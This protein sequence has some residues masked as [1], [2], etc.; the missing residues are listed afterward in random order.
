MIR[1]ISAGIDVGSSSTRVVVGEKLSGE[2]NP[3]ILGAGEAPT[4]GVRRGYVVDQKLAT[5]SIRKALAEAERAAGIKIKHAVVSMGSV[6]LK[7]EQ[8]VGEIVVSK[9]DGEVTRLDVNRALEDAEENLSLQNKK[10]IQVF[11]TLFRVDGK[12][13]LG[14]PEG[15]R[16]TKLEVKALFVTCSTQHLDDLLSAVSEAGVRPADVIPSPIAGS[17]IAMSEK[18]K[19]VGAGLVDIG[20]ESVSLAVFENGTLASLQSFP[21]GG[22]D[23]TNDIALGLKISLEEAESLKLGKILE[24][25][26][27]KKLDEII[28]ARM[29][30]VFELVENHLK[31]IKRNGL[32]P[33]GVVFIGGGANVKKIEEF[34]KAALKLPSKMG[35]TDIFGSAKTR[36]RDPAW[37]VALGLLAGEDGDEGYG[38]EGVGGVF[39]DLKSAIKSSIKQLMP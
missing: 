22:N 12:E 4:L 23:V 10:V 37:F 1:N 16:G 27:Q 20:S 7:G 39:Q 38:S 8:S 5:E 14:R 21:I 15:M 33:A 19:I 13:I 11:P 28:E 18:Q 3:K 35:A 36:L 25:H 6:T 34:S 30:D 32:L 17:L 24:D 9:A 26:S 29:S 2:K 31:K